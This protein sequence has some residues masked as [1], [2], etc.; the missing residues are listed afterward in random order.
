MGKSFPPKEKLSAC[1][2]RTR[3]EE[4]KQAL[5]NGC[6]RK[7]EPYRSYLTAGPVEKWKIGLSVLSMF[8]GQCFSPLGM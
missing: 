3:K 8:M 2:A 5:Y 4:R 1:L 7:L 6:T